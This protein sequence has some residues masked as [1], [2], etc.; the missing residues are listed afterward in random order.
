MSIY[1]LGSGKMVSITTDGKNNLAIGTILQMN[2][3]DNP[4]KVIV[5]KIGMSAFSGGM[6][7]K[8]IGLKSKDFG[9]CDAAGLK[10]LS[11]KAD[12][13][14][15]FYITD[16]VLGADEIL[17][18]MAEA[19]A[20]VVLKEAATNEKAAHVAKM[21][22]DLPILH[23]D[24]LTEEKAKTLF[25]KPLSGA[26]LGAKNIKLQLAKAF[27]GVKFGVKSS[28][29]AGGC[30]IDVSWTDG[31]TTEAVD[32]IADQYQ[33]KDFDGMDDSTHYRD[34]V[35][36]DI[37]GGA[38]YVMCNRHYSDA[39]MDAVAVEMGFTCAKWEPKCGS[40]SGVTYEQSDMIKRAAWQK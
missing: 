23:P 21:K 18:L 30:S 2:G 20:Q 29:Y 31:P 34:Q 7:Y 33:E 27:P 13:R 39:F 37:F 38:G 16:E 35:W 32:K 6:M 4:K 26:A 10:F 9:G 25:K 19:Q 24:L 14:I 12:N 36:T 17:D 15:A 5:K 22:A 40:Y 8:T 11:E 1:E 3:Y 28:Y